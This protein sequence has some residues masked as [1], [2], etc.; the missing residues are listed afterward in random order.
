M[1]SGHPRDDVRQHLFFEGHDVLDPVDPGEFGVDTGELSS[2]PGGE[3]GL[4][5][6]H[7]SYLE[8]AVDASRDR[9][10]PISF[11]VCISVQPCA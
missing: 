6:E 11:G 10:L 2:V 9:Q 1:P 7:W 4:G 3:R 5:P 8:D